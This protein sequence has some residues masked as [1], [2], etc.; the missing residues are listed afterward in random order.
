MLRYVRLSVRPSVWLSVCPIVQKR[1]I[2]Q[3]LYY[4]TLRG[5]NVNQLLIAQS[6]SNAR[7]KIIKIGQCLFKL[8]LKMSE[9]LFGGHSVER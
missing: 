2:G 5:G 9:M 7:A 1:F 3:W 4:N 8:Q 6:L